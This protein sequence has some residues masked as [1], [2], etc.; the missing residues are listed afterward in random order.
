MLESNSNALNFNKYLLNSASFQLSKEK[1]IFGEHWAF[2]QT[3]CRLQ[4][5]QFNFMQTNVLPTRLLNLV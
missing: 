1:R 3:M 2:V 4:I 5:T